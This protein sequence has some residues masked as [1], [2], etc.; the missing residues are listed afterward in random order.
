MGTI[1]FRQHDNAGLYDHEGYLGHVFEDG[2]IH[3]GGDVSEIDRRTVGW[4]AMCECGWQGAHIVHRGNSVGVGLDWQ[5]APALDAEWTAH[6]DPLLADLPPTDPVLARAVAELE[7][8]AREIKMAGFQ[9]Y[10]RN[11]LEMINRR[12]AKLKTGEPAAAD[13]GINGL[14]Y[15][16]EDIF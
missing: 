4:R 14:G 7:G 11:V 10:K 9:Y 6:T 16:P 12:I 1:R 2:S 3:G 8:L 5:D 15:S 13:E